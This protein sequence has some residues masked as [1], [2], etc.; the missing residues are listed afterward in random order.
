MTKTEDSPEVS[1]WLDDET[2]LVRE[3]SD[4]KP[5]YDLEERTARFG[6]AVID[7]A[8]KMPRD[9]VTDRIVSQLV[10]AGTSVGGNYTEADDSVSKKEFLKCIGTCKK[11]ARE[12]KF[13]LRMAARA[14][15][16]L[17]SEARELWMEGRELHLIFA[18][19][20]R[21]GKRQE[22]TKDE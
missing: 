11:E 8:K 15:P 13:F 17:R 18:R 3:E 2:S 6:E 21:T 22:M 20:W 12:T 14:V 5:I 16:Q 10:G 19:I 7:F 9:P 4:S 1:F